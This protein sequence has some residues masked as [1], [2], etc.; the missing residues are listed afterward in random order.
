M[1][2]AKNRANRHI[3]RAFC[4]P[5]DGRLALRIT[6][7][8]NAKGWNHRELRQRLSDISCDASDYRVHGWE[9][10]F[11]PRIRHIIP[12][13][14]VFQILPEELVRGTEIE[15]EL[16]LLTRIHNAR[17]PEIRT[18]ADVLQAFMQ[19]GVLE[20]RESR[21]ASI[22]SHAKR[23][24]K[25]SGYESLE[26]CP[27]SVFHKTAGEI[28]EVID[29]CFTRETSIHDLRNFKNNVCF[30]VREASLRNLLPKA[31]STYDE[32]T[33]RRMRDYPPV[34]GKNLFCKYRLSA[35]ELEQNPDFKAQL[36]DFRSFSSDPTK[37][38][39]DIHKRDITIESYI[40][41]FRLIAGVYVHHL[42]TKLHEISL[43]YLVRPDNVKSFVKWFIDTTKKRQKDLY[44]GLDAEKCTG[45]TKT[46]YTYVIRLSTTAK[47]FLK[48]PQTALFIKKEILAYLP[49]PQLVKIKESR[50]VTIP[51]LEK[52]GRSIYPFTAKR[53]A[54]SEHVRRTLQHLIAF[55][56][57]PN[58]AVLKGP[59]GAEKKPIFRGTGLAIRVC[60]S[61]IIRLLVRIP[62]R[63]RNIREMEIDKNLCRKNGTYILRFSARQLKVEYVRGKPKTIE[64]G[65]EPDDT[66]FIELMNEWF[67]IWRPFLAITGMLRREQR[68]GKR[69]A[70]VFEEIRSQKFTELLSSDKIPCLGPIRN[71]FINTKGQPMSN[72][73]IYEHL[74]RYT[75]RYTGKS[76]NPHLFR[77]IWVTDYLRDTRNKDGSC[78]L[79]GA[80]W[81]LGNTVQSVEKY[82]AHILDESTGIR[83]RRWLKKRLSES[84]D[85]E[86]NQ[87]LKIIWRQ[88]ESNKD[89][90]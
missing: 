81:M 7:L 13:S 43:E 27:V 82:Y 90:F 39:R 71:V 19:S 84:P 80:A 5:F 63:V 21:A 77:D 6:S 56:N 49:H 69:S 22:F 46:L 44:L 20:G 12:I 65:I 79:T 14:R 18:A 34:R 41:L 83:P 47:Y 15:S 32:K 51:E 76:I 62:L 23:F 88:D 40:R 28:R 29:K 58:E 48:D 89:R 3:Q 54:E 67:C 66:E 70:D 53:M 61:L 16:A 57:N 45:V 31:D 4:T 1:R 59:M 2:N 30:F 42:K 24:A 64:Y 17:Q 73:C 68:G 11:L 10:S 50:M 55:V 78:D 86:L 9:N 74:T 33:A 25:I 8:R 36:E 38:P 37:G 72:D 60:I 35:S 52:I 85:E 87:S 26:A 75:F